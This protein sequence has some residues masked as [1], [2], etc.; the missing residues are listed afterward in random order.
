[1]AGADPGAF[2]F[3]EV[4]TRLQVEHGVTEAVTGIDLVAWMLQLAAGEPPDLAGYRHAPRGVAIQARLY[5]ED[6]ARS[7]RPASGLLTEVRLPDTLRVDTLD[8]ERQRGAGVLRSDARQADRACADA[9]RGDR[10]SSMPRS[11]EARSMASKPT[12]NTCAPSCASPASGAPDTPHAIPEFAALQLTQH[13]GAAAR[14]PQHAC[15]I[16]RGACTTGTS[17]CRPPDRW[18]RWR[19]GSAIDCWAIRGLCRPGADGDRAD[20]EVRLRCAHCA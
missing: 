19:S 17:A 7:F 16:G 11:G 18:T 15:R 12:S 5:A 8:R 6:P 9:R 1:M 4:N 20:A 3:L 10:R 2:Y 14:D 13:R